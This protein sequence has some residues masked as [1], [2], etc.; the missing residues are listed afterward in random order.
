MK[1]G[2]RRQSQLPSPLHCPGMQATYLFSYILTALQV[3]VPIGEDLRLHDG[4][5]AILWGEG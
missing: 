3:V 5:D 2:N 4:H 1:Y